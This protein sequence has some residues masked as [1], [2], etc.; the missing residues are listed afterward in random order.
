MTLIEMLIAIIIFCLILY[1]SLLLLRYIYK[2]YGYAMEQGMSVTAAQRGLKTAVKDI[3][4]LGQSDSGAYPIESAN[5]FDFVFYSDIDKDGVMERVHY[6]KDGDKIKR[7]IRKP[8]GTPPVYAAG[9]QS[10]ATEVEKVVNTAQ[11][12]LFYFY[13]TNYP[14]DQTH[15]PLATPVSPVADIRLVKVDIYVNINPNRAPDNVRIESFVELRNL[16]DNW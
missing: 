6:F 7:G 14:A 12:P 2:N 16:K 3:R 4:G 15:N 8:S 11:Q 13:N 5:K 1:G 9:D 10:V